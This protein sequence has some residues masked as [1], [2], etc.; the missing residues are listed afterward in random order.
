MGLIRIGQKR[1]G[2]KSMNAPAGARVASTSGWKS[3]TSVRRR[4]TLTQ[5]RLPLLRTPIRGRCTKL[6]LS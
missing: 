6:N 4:E 5:K 1:N 3:R 2:K